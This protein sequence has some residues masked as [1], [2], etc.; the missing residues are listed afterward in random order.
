MKEL[1]KEQELEVFKYAFKLHKEDIKI[2]KRGHYELDGMCKLLSDALIKYGYYPYG[3][4]CLRERLPKFKELTK[5]K[6]INK[7]VW[8]IE[9][10][11]RT[12][13]NHFKRIIKELKQETKN[14]KL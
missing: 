5:G 3:F 9:N 2:S 14:N 10:T 1:N 7:Y 12:R 8:S 6:D 11:N 13:Y 4:K